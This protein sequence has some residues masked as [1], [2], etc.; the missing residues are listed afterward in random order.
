MPDGEKRNSNQAE[1]VFILYLYNQIGETMAGE[2][3]LMV[4]AVVEEIDRCIR[5]HEDEKATLVSLSKK[6]GFS[7]FH[8][9]RKFREISGM[10]FREYLR[11][12]S[13]AFSLKDVRDTKKGLLEIALEHG[14]SS[15]EA[16]TRSFKESYGMT[17]SEFRANPRPVALRTVIRPFDCFLAQTGGFK[18]KDENGKN[19]TGEIRTYFVTIPAH[20]YLHIRNYE[21]IGYWDFW[22]RQNKI[23]GQDYE[24]ICGI[25]E[26]IPGKL[27][28]ADRLWRSS[29]SRREESAAGE[30]LLR[31]VTVCGFRRTG[32]AKCRH[33]CS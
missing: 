22:Q 10:S 29:T 19:S 32:K 2:W 23:P 15:H 3:H 9:S 11:E 18:M 25:L 8:V 16:F 21:S 31:K 12:R 7:E 26:S 5:N 20:K 4:Q 28:D 17:P 30:F 1:T 24:T 14:F 13:L 33:R 6:L 27:D